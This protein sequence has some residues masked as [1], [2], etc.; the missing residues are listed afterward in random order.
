MGSPYPVLNNGLATTQGI[1]DIVTDPL[2]K[3]GTRASLTDGRVYYYARQTASGAIVAGNIL[4]VEIG[5]QAYLDNIVTGTHAVGDMAIDLTP[6]TGKTWD[7]NEFA[8]G[9]VCIDTATTGAGTTYKIKSH[10]AVSSATLF[11][12]EL[13]DPIQVAVHS[14]ATS[15]VVKNPWMDVIIASNT[16]AYMPAGVAN[17]AIPAGDSTAQY[18]WCQTW[19][20]A[21]VT[22]GATSVSGELL[23]VDT[24]TAGETLKQTAGIPIVGINMF[25]AANATWCPTFLQISA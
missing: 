6:T 1:M 12:A 2:L 4:Q 24:T 16:V 19:G 23:M 17:I 5:D 18:F 25:T 20:M 7:A 22:S 21:A 9:Y 13:Y 14:D 10:G 15:T 11:S 3:V 8:E